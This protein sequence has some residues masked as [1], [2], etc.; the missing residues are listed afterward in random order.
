MKSSSSN[1]TKEEGVK[2]IMPTRL[3][4]RSLLAAFLLLIEDIAR[5]AAER[6]PSA[7]GAVTD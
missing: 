7:C 2:S 4:V 1:K 3:E 6:G 5:H